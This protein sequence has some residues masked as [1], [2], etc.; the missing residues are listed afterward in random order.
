MDMSR[1]DADQPGTGTAWWA[2]RVGVVPVA[3]RQS[4]QHFLT[5]LAAYNAAP[6]G[7]A[8]HQLNVAVSELIEALPNRSTPAP[9]RERL[10]GILG[11]GKLRGLFHS[12]T[13]A[14]MSDSQ[15]LILGLTNLLAMVGG[16]TVAARYRD[17]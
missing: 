2:S 11:D 10:A 7:S 6:G 1:W 4:F 17:F 14:P 8:L 13:Y 9:V 3:A 12:S 15:N 16:S 5:A